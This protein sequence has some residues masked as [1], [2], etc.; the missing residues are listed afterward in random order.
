M[1]VGWFVAF[2]ILAARKYAGGYEWF[3]DKEFWLFWPAAIMLLAWAVIVLPVLAFARTRAILSSP[4]TAWLAWAALSLISFAILVL[5][6]MPAYFVLWFPTIAGATAG[7][8]FPFILRTNASP[9]IL[10]S[11][12]I[13][14]VV[15]WFYVVWPLSMR[16]ATHIAYPLG[17]LKEQQ[18][19]MD[20]VIPKLREGMT[21]EELNALF[22]N[23]SDELFISISSSSKSYEYS[24][25]LQ[26][27][28]V[29]KVDIQEKR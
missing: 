7:I 21:F 16:Y 11:T 29:T 9:F 28:I 14:A 25:K 2:S 1:S 20:Y 23:K 15:G 17:S 12:P 24:I 18:K 22:P 26:D 5:W 19:M 4:K 13:L 8:V 6:W 27:G 10:F 3:D